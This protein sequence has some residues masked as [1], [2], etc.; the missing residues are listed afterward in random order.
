MKRP[1]AH[2]ENSFL[3]D[4]KELDT[5]RYV[6]LKHTPFIFQHPA[7]RN[8]ESIRDFLKCG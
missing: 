8:P 5:Q 1:A 6:F 2:R 3:G 4:E 7:S